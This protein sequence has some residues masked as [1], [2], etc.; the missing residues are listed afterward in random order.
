MPN[1]QVSLQGLYIKAY[2]VRLSTYSGLRSMISQ[3]RALELKL[4][5][6]ACARESMSEP[7][8]FDLPVPSQDDIGANVRAE[9]LQ[10]GMLEFN[11]AHRTLVATPPSPMGLQRASTKKIVSIFRATIS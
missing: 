10:P 9:L 6:T 8:C 4:V 3:L 7:L 1:A 2:K 5:T 11:G